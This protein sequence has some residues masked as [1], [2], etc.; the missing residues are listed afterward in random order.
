MIR[1]EALP[2]LKDNYVWIIVE[3]DKRIATIVD[4]G[5]AAPVIDYLEK[6]KLRLLAI[7]LTH[8]HLDHCGGVDDLVRRY[9][10]PVYAHY[11]EKKA[12]ASQRL[13]DGEVF[14]L[15]DSELRW[16]ALAIPGHTLGHCAFKFDKHLFTGDTLFSLGCGRIFEGNAKMMWHSLVK[17]CSYDDDT[18]IY[19][20]HEY[21]LANCR[22]AEFI[23][24]DNID[25]L[26]YKK[27]ILKKIAAGLPT[28]PSS[29]KIEKLS[30]PFLQCHRQIIQL[31]VSELSNT[32]AKQAIEVFSM[33][34]EL[35]NS[36]K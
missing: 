31:R 32:S 19:P 28:L 4:P 1:I 30:N 27:L 8:H 16:Q 15:P 25:L 10:V 14:S 5:E 3:Q 21:T 6:Y 35:K 20:G 9:S 33:M 2:V 22:F 11:Q 12:S 23:Q 7:L 17:L 13:N 18:L 29:L 36:F 24:P 34:R 26:D